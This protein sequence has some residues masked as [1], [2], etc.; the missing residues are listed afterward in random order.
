VSRLDDLAAGYARLKQGTLWHT[1]TGRCKGFADANPGEAAKLDAYVAA[2]VAG[3][4]AVMPV[5]ATATGQ[6]LALMIRAL[7]PLA[8]AFH[9]T[10]KGT[11]QQGQT[12]TAVI[13]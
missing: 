11:A 1:Q 9:V 8:A 2:V 10:L 7:G 5:L 12:M 4:P 6:G 13:T 3:K